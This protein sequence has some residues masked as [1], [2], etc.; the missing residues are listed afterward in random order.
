VQRYHHDAVRVPDRFHHVPCEC[1]A[2][3]PQLVVID[4]EI[5]D[6]RVVYRNIAAEVGEVIN[7]GYRRPVPEIVGI[8]KDARPSTAIF[9]PR[10]SLFA[11]ANADRASS[12]MCTGM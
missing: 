4:I 8:R 2:F 5:K 10:M 1:Y 6:E 11:S 9:E 12:T 7:N 3:F